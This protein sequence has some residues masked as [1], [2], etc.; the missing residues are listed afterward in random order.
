MYSWNT[1]ANWANRRA[2]PTTV[3]VGTTTTGAPGS[4]ASVTNSGTSTRC[5]IKFRYSCW[6]YWANG[7]DWSYWSNMTDRG[8]FDSPWADP[9]LLELRAQRDQ[10][11]PAGATGATGPTGP[12]GATGATGATD[13]PER[14]QQ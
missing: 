14:L 6:S 12:V 4:P 8:S 11:L 13:Q 10:Q 7:C 3:I 5:N 9:D 2:G 1:G